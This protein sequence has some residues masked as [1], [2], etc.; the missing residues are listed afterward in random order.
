[1]T[2]LNKVNVEVQVEKKID[3]RTNNTGRPVNKKSARQQ[4]LAKQALYSKLNKQFI[5]GK[6]FK[7]N[8]RDSEYVY[9]VDTDSKRKNAYG[10]ISSV[11]GHECNVSYVG[12]TK[13]LGYTFVL[14]KRVNVAINLKNVEFIK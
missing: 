5:Q 12:R 11:T 4:R 6:K 10:H 14:G 8:N 1:M 13:V 9:H 3:N 2:K 7:I